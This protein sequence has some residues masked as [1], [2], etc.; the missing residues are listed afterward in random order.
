[1]KRGAVIDFWIGLGKSSMEMNDLIQ[2]VYGMEAMTRFKVFTRCKEF[3]DGRTTTE[4]VAGSSHPQKVRTE[5]MVVMLATLIHMD[6]SLTV[7]LPAWLVGSVHT[8]LIKDL[9]MQH[10]CVVWV[11]NLLTCEQLQKMD[12]HEPHLETN[13]VWRQL[14]PQ[15]CHNCWWDLGVQ[16]QSSDKMGKCW[17]EGIVFTTIKDLSNKI[18]HQ[19]AAL[20]VLQ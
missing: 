11:P 8:M 10:I 6:H 4:H 15:L 9:K 13:V 18:S 20:G 17:V 12:R 19:S 7:Q 14:I 1:M 3:C 5:V 2:Q 16:T